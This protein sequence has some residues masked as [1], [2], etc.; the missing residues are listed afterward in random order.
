MG[1]PSR[2]ALWTRL[3]AQIQLKVP[4]GLCRRGCSVEHAAKQRGGLLRRDVQTGVSDD[5]LRHPVARQLAG[6]HR[7]EE[8]DAALGGYV[9]QVG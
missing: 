1:W 2:A 5:P 6:A 8:P 7:V 3:Q 4:R 9:G